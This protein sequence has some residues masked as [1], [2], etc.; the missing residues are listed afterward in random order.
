MN[1]MIKSWAIILIT[2]TALIAAAPP[3]AGL[4]GG[5]KSY[6][7][8]LFCGATQSSNRICAMQPCDFQ[9]P[10]DSGIG[11]AQLC[12]IDLGSCDY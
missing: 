11:Q 7:G 1:R 5:C 12:C 3:L 9:V 2:V 10:G 4:C 6:S 8:L